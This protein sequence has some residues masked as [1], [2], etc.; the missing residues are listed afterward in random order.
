MIISASLLPEYYSQCER[1]CAEFNFTVQYC[2]L[3]RGLIFG[4]KEY[5]L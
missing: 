1:L 2:V 5:L 3:L 4:E